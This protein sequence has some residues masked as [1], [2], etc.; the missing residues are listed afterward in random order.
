[1]LTGG[2]GAD[3]FRYTANTEG[4]DTITDFVSGTDKIGVLAALVNNGTNSTTLLTLAN[5]AVFTGGGTAIG[6][7]DVFIEITASGTTANVSTAAGMDAWIGNGASATAMSNI[8]S[9]DKVLI[10]VDD[11]TDGYLWQ[12]VDTATNTGVV[13]A[14]ELTLIAK[15]TGVTDIAN[16]DLAIVT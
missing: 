7:N 16:G 6:A 11:G 1:M 13:D 4:G 10:F 15:L 14:A 2:A 5:A 9:G 8:A 3:T 12:W